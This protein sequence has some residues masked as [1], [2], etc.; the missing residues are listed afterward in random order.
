MVH[1][2]SV[3]IAGDDRLG[4]LGPV[5]PGEVT[6]EDSSDPIRRRRCQ[7]ELSW[8]IM[9]DRPVERWLR[10]ADDGLKTKAQLNKW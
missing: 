7:R 5:R 9:R 4:A 6:V 2:P 10:V 8:A 3:V 1:V